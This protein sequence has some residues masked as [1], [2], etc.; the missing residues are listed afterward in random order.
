[1]YLYRS[2]DDATQRTEK[3]S[4]M[5]GC[6]WALSIWSWERLPVGRPE[7]LPQTEW[8]EYGEDG[9]RSRYPT[10]AYSWDKVKVF[11]GKES[12]MYKAFTNE[13]DNLTS[14][15]VNWWLYHDRAWGF[16]LNE[17][18]ERDRLL[19]WCIVPLICVYAVEWHLPQRVATQ[20]GVLQH[21]PPARPHDTGGYDLHKKSNQYS[22]S[23]LDWADEHKSFV[24]MWDERTFR[25]D[26]E[27]SG[28]CWNV[29]ERH[30]NWYDDGIKFRLHLRPRWTEV[31]MASLQEEEDSED[32][33]T[34]EICKV[35]SGS[36]RPL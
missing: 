21:T 13:L 29:Y 15:Q 19:F 30:M 17:M 6:V 3:T 24:T 8:T 2:L 4:G 23:I 31:D 28:I 7:K 16:E 35:I 33:E 26:G 11:S 36:M 10:V 22:Q 12:A 27:R 18:C 34:S 14:F 32:E 1:M 25:K 20:F 5:C 9:D